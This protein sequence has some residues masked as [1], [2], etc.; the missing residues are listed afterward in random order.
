MGKSN[1]DTEG[2]VVAEELRSGKSS[3]VIAALGSGNGECKVN[4]P[5][6]E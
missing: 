1:G 6:E 4:E 2:S 5:P 3:S